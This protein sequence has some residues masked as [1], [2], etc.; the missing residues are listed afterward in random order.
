MPVP[1]CLHDAALE[2]AKTGGGPLNAIVALNPELKD[3]PSAP[4]GCSLC[5]GAIAFRRA[6][7]RGEDLGPNGANQLFQNLNL[8]NGV[9]CQHV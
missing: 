1:A 2:C 5:A 7:D 9:P 6:R 4:R 8:W 3:C